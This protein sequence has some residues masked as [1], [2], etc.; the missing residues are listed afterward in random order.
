M[1]VLLWGLESDSPLA[2]VRKELAHL[3]VVTVFIDQRR[4]LETQIETTVGETV[5]GVVRLAGDSMD[6]ADVGSVYLRPYESTR[7]PHIAAAGPES[8]ERR[9]A[10]MVDDILLS[11][12]EIT[13]AFVVNRCSAMAGNG[14]K[15]YQL[16]QI[17]E[18]GWS[19]PDTLVTTDAEEAR[20]FWERHGEIIYKSVSSVRSRVT[21]LQARHAERFDDLATCPTQ[22]Q[23]YI[24]GEDYRVHVVGEQVFASKIKSSADDYRFTDV[25]VPEIRPSTLPPELEERCRMTSAALELP[26]AGIDLRRNAQGEWF[27]FE[28]NP[29]PAFTYYEEATEQP[30]GQAVAQLLA[31]AAWHRSEALPV[32][33]VPVAEA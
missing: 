7:L 24:T 21:R 15:P 32:V 22:L 3:D 12:S 17:R 25:E 1:L 9:H 20:A 16:Q 5:E 6:L 19:V 27:C 29:S 11:W 30:I 10:A 13:P 14:S 18:L 2:A 23:H 26:F 8:A 31:S 28:V 4:V 33:S